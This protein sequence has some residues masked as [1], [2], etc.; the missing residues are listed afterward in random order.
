M[1][2]LPHRRRF[3]RGAGVAL[4]LPWLEALAP[5]ASA[6][7]APQGPPRRLVVIA[8][9]LGMHAP[10]FFP[11][12]TG[13]DFALPPLLEPLTGLRS[14][15]TVFSGLSHPDVDGG[16]SSE[17]CLLTAAPHPA[18]P[19]FKNS[20]SLDQ[21]LL[22]KLAP[23]TRTPCLNLS[24]LGGSP[25]S[26]SR[27]GVNLPADERPSRVFARLF[28]DGSRAEIAEQQRKLATGKSVL[29][30]VQAQAKALERSLPGKDR[31]K[32][33]EYLSAVREVEQRLHQAD[34]WSRKPKPKVAVKPPMDIVNPAD[35]FGRTRLLLDV[36]HLA[37]ETDSTRVI[38]VAIR[39]SGY[40]L[41]ISGVT[42]DWH[43]LTH[44]GQDAAK[45]E[46]LRRIEQAQMKEL[47]TFLTKL[48][49]SAEAGGSLLDRTAVL[50]GSNLGN[51]SSHDTHNLPI[52]LA[53]G[54]FKHGQ[55]LAFDRKNNE[56]LPKLFVSL[57]QRFGVEVD[58]FAGTTG[59][60][61]GLELSAG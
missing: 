3:L 51:A 43:N 7:A 21:F 15:W 54:G 30:A 41:P 59:T 2:T 20:I 38:C 32:L 4:A 47:A 42:A 9:V 50:F 16:H 53:G 33:D 5:R 17:N 36:A 8:S 37:L 26:W 52:L 24:T 40:V 13:R 28:L 14:D 29:D 27:R 25:L 19:T 49:G 34:A 45:I 31:E 11:Q 58:S 12:K 61:T 23:P 48:K 39:G 18:R 57:M 44:H 46:Q 56:A 22:E 60:L 10:L 35:A 1:T 6:L 55:H